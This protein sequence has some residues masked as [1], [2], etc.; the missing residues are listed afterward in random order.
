MEILYVLSTIF[1]IIGFLAAK[2]SSEKLDFI[3]W[4]IISIVTLYGYNICIGMILGVLN[5]KSF[6][7]LLAAINILFGIS[8]LYKPIFKRECQE[9]K[10]SKFEIVFT[11]LCI[12]IMCIMFVHDLYIYNGDI[13]H[14]A[15]DSAIH[16][17]AAKHY[18]DYL[19]TF[20]NIENRSFFNFNIMQPGAY[21]ND[22]IFMNVIH[23][24]TGLDYTYIYQIFETITLFVSGAAFLSIFI[25]KVKTK[26][27][28]VASVVLFA[29]YMYG[30]PYNSWIYGFSYLSV[31][32]M[33]V[34]S[35]IPIVEMLF[36]EEK[37]LRKVSIPLIGIIAT[38]LIYSYCLF[39]P[40]VFASI[41]IYCFINDLKSDEKKCFKIFGKNT[42]IV[43][44]MLLFVTLCG[45]LYLFI[46]SFTTEGQTDLVSALSIDGAIYSE[47]YKN[48][49]VYIPFGIIY[50]F[51]LF[52][53][54]KNKEIKYF[55]IFAILLV[56]FIGTLYIGMIMGKVAPYYML[57]TYFILWIVIFSATSDIV[58]SYSEE[59]LFRADFIFM[60][61]LFPIF[62]LKGFSIESIIRIYLVLILAIYM[63][64]PNLKKSILEY[65]FRVTACTYVI[66]WGIFVGFWCELKAGHII[67]ETEKHALPN[68]VGMYY[69]ENCEYRKLIDLNNNFNSNEI[70]LTTYARDNLEDMTVENTEL[71]TEGYYTRI[72][73]TAV[74]ELSS[75]TIPYQN[76][77][78]DTKIYTIDDALSDST[79]KYI[80]KLVSKDK[81]KM[82]EYKA[83][84]IDI[85]SN[86]SIEILKE[87]ENG[88][89]AKIN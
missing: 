2:K 42:I 4:L 86:P 44:V 77:I 19:T 27:G 60:M 43:T 13:S 22:G 75:D 67:G 9:Y 49:L 66:V 35:L 30:Y 14:F 1:L 18:S 21:I 31:G 54:F 69:I 6:I 15:V 82:D 78:Q 89:V 74:S 16:Y 63:A 73:A 80:I 11:L 52:K 32:I 45:I 36:S 81:T 61:L 83:E 23:G 62:V 8:F 5:I 53:R 70:E 12:C 33:F 38:G 87:N 56:C 3:K 39:V 34:A 25:D 85:K 68:L 48:F 40:P 50:L 41:C 46:P 65:G 88:F 37:V 57:K 7:W 64:I 20:L 59:K 71:M 58:N 10:V 79:K 29:L 28:L 55:D 24:I 26:K 76:V 47:K 84:L 17:R 51:D 72:W